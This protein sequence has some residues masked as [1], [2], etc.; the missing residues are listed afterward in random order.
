MERK[1][2]KPKQKF[3]LKVRKGVCYGKT[4]LLPEE[5]GYSIYF[6]PS[7]FKGTWLKVWECH[8]YTIGVDYASSQENEI[9]NKMSKVQEKKQK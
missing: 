8:D 5:E 9:L 2:Q 4:N 1:S 6:V 3:E 7:G